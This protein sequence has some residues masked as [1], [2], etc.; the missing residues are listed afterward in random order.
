GEGRRA[1]HVSLRLGERRAGRGHRRQGG[2]HLGRSRT[3]ALGGSGQSC[4]GRK[5][6]GHRRAGGGDFSPIDLR[7]AIGG[8]GDERRV[9]KIRFQTPERA[10]ERRI[11]SQIVEREISE[12]AFGQVA[13]RPSPAQRVAPV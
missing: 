8:G 3:A 12:G 9:H 11:R 4:H 5:L 7:R 10:C 1:P 13:R 6:C 2:R